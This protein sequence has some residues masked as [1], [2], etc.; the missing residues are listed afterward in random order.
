MS[1]FDALPVILVSAINEIAATEL[2]AE[3]IDNDVT[4]DYLKETKCLDRV[5]R[6]ANKYYTVNVRVHVLADHERL[7]VNPN[8][9]EAHVILITKEELADSALSVARAE[10]RAAGGDVWRRAAVRLLL[11][12]AAADPPPLRAWAARQRADCV[13]LRAPA[14]HAAPF[15]EEAGLPRARAVLQAHTWR[16]LQRTDRAPYAPP[17]GQYLRAAER[18]PRTPPESPAGSSC[19]GSDDSACSDESDSE[20]EERRAVEQ[21]EAFAAALGAL[22]PA[23]QARAEPQGPEGP[24]G[25]PPELRRDQAEALVLA[26]CRALGLDPSSC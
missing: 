24:A 22:G 10:A 9:I 2:I 8:A 7:G 25:G 17:P 16:G 1:T 21:A 26:F 20:A 14:A 13:P 5:W 11:A 15:A 19:A 23:L 4:D 6:L 18:P 3:L 12:D